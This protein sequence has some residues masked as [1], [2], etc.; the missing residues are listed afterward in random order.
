MPKV[1]V[2]HNVVDVDKLRALHVKSLAG[3][4]SWLSPSWTVG[5]IAEQAGARGRMVT[6]LTN[7]H[8]ASFRAFTDP[9]ASVSF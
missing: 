6:Q 1:V 3:V 4:A 5:A 9:I 7:S 8:P 2:T